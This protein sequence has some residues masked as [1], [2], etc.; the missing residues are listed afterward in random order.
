MSVLDWQFRFAIS[1]FFPYSF[2]L[3]FLIF[4]FIFLLCQTETGIIFLIPLYIYIYIKYFK[5]YYTKKK[6]MFSYLVNNSYLITC[7]PNITHTYQTLSITIISSCHTVMSHSHL[8]PT[9]LIAKSIVFYLYSNDLAQLYVVNGCNILC[10][11]II[12]LKFIIIIL[13]YNNYVLLNLQ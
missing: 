7:H 5:I 6:I 13:F 8:T 11:I 4:N 2:F 3:F 1:F 9:L 12:V 10:Y